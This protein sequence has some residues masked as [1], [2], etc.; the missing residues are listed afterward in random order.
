MDAS[1]ERNFKDKQKLEEPLTQNEHL[2]KL[3]NEQVRSYSQDNLQS[4]QNDI[5][6]SDLQGDSDLHSQELYDDSFR[7]LQTKNTTENISASIPQF[8]VNITDYKA[9]HGCARLNEM[10]CDNSQNYISQC[11]RSP[12]SNCN[13]LDTVLD[14]RKVS[15]HKLFSRTI[16]SR[17]L[18]I[19]IFGASSK[20]VNIKR[21]GRGSAVCLAV[22]CD[23][24]GHSYT[25]F[26]PEHYC[27]KLLFTL[28]LVK[29]IYLDKIITPVSQ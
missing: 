19:S 13:L 3:I 2:N 16:S 23:S 8:L 20:C 24:L 1:D 10:K 12:H 11:S 14:C 6:V 4:K 9:N 21:R 22:Q 29:W 27:K 18:K 26:F 7:V 25:I 17:N 5:P 28:Y 15:S